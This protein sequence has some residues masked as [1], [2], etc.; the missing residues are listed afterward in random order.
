MNT[1]RFILSIA[2]GLIAHQT[3]PLFEHLE[4]AEAVGAG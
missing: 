4:T 3:N 2:A 1:I